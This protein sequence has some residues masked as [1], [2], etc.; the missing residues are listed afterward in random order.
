MENV[1]TVNSEELLKE[2]F[3]IERT[4]VLI[5]QSAC[6]KE[7]QA[8][9]LLEIM[10]KYS[11]KDFQV[12]YLE[13]GGLFRKNIPGYSDYMRKK[14][15]DTNDAG[16]LQSPAFAIT[17]WAGAVLNAWHGKGHMLID[18]APRSEEEARS[19]FS[20]Y[21]KA[22]GREL[23]VFHIKIPDDVAE[24]RMVRRNLDLKSK[25]ETPRKDS[26]TPESR[27]RKLSFY[28]DYVKDAIV[29]LE[30]LDVPVHKINGEKTIQ[31][32]SSEILFKLL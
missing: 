7:T 13:S 26:A 20:M 30:D 16:D 2:I 22:L 3:S 15:E 32:I 29:F 4:V 23:V 8:R 18:G 17:Q 14:L 11:P 28:N 31:E 24:E 27:K 12:L 10:D 19:M 9:I 25:G 1:I 21:T 6:G 5:G